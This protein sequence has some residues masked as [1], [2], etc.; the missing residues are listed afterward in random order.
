MILRLPTYSDAEKM[1]NTM[2][3]PNVNHYMTF[4][5]KIFSFDEIILFIEKAKRDR[6]NLHLVVVSD[7]NDYLGSVSLKNLDFINRRS[8]YSIALSPEVLGKGIA[9]HATNTLFSI[10]FNYLK[11]NSIYLSVKKDNIRAI[12]FYEKSGFIPTEFESL[13][14]DS[15]SNENLIWFVVKPSSN[16]SNELLTMVDKEVFVFLNTILEA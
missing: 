5:D 14:L 13:A 3:N 4:K 6:K 2:S 15:K 1:L 10:A 7:D 11:L 16:Y 8:E 9:A 12:R